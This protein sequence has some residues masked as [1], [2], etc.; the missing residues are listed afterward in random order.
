MF[1]PRALAL[2]IRNANDCVNSGYPSGP[3]SLACRT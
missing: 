1:V 3:I 2:A